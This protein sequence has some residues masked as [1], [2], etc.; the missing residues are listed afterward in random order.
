MKPIPYQAPKWIFDHHLV[1]KYYHNVVKKIPS[2]R[3]ELVS[4]KPTPIDRLVFFPGSNISLPS[5]YDIWIKRDDLTHHDV[6][7]QGNKLRKLEF[8]FADALN[9][10]AQHVLSAG[11]LQSNHC[12]TV[13]AV[14]ARLGLKAHLFLRSLN[15]DRT[16]VR[17]A[18][19]FSTI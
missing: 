8:L 16:K 13:A 14:A 10:N 3:L 18:L 7:M 2:H 9:Q 6:H 4:K 19:F 1:Q 5:G 11:G 17:S 15:S 12:R